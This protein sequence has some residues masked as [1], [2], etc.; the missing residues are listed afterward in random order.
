MDRHIQLQRLFVG[1]FLGFPP[2]EDLVIASRAR[3]RG[4]SRPASLARMAEEFDPE[5]YMDQKLDGQEPAALGPPPGAPPDD[6]AERGD[7]RKK[8]SKRDRSRSRSRDRR[9]SRSVC[10][11]HPAGFMAGKV[12]CSLLAA[13]VIGSLSLPPPH[14]RTRSLARPLSL[15]FWLS[16]TLSCSLS[17]WMQVKG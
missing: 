5:K 17:C 11:H 12:V 15:P 9:R 7:D 8:S 14:T 6:D 4:T 13:G 2:V 16:H 1:F 10:L 3:G